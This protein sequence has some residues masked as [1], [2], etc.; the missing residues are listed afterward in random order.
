MAQ[1]VTGLRELS[2][3]FP[4]LFCDIWGV[5][6][7]G[8]AAF[9]PACEALTRYRAEGGVVIL[10]S[11]APRPHGSVAAQIAALGVPT[12]AYDRIVSSGDLT[13]RL[14]TERGSQPLHH[15][16]PPKDHALFEGLSAPRVAVRDAAYIVCTGLDDDETQTAGDYRNVLEEALA[17]GL[18]MI[19]ANPD[20]SIE[21]GGRVVPCAGAIAQAYLEIGGEVVQAGKPHAPIYELA[22]AELGAMRGGL[23]R[24]DVLAIGDSLRTDIAG[25]AGFGL[26]SLFVAE[27]LHAGDI[28]GLGGEGALEAACDFARSRSPRADHV[29]THLRW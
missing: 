26:A 2:L 15:I 5:V 1:P 22:M 13:R 21:R 6:H 10:L 18:M 27:G 16:G 28:G 4:A 9:G 25:A 11:N 19:C 29:M 3:R 7:N 20:L 8:I 17:R 14:I 24:S 12:T 23:A